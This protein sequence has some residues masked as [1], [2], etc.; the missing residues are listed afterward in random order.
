MTVGVLWVVLGAVLFGA[1]TLMQAHALAAVPGRAGAPLLRAVRHPLFLVG[2]AA[3][4]G[5]ALAH[6][7][8]LQSVPMAVAQAAVS[9]SLAVTVL[10]AR[11][12]FGSRVGAS[13]IVAVAVL[14][15]AL[16]ALA[17]VSGESGT[18]DE[19]GP[20]TV[21]LACAT[22]LLGIGA[23]LLPALDPRR[24][25]VVAAVVSGLG[26]AACSIATRLLDT[27]SLLAPLTDP[28]L[29]VLA[30]AG[31]LGALTWTV[32]LR[33]GTATSVTAIVV[34]SEVVPPSLLGPWLGDDVGTGFA[35]VAPLALLAAS[36]AA[37]T[38]ARLEHRTPAV[39]GGRGRSLEAPATAI[40]DAEVAR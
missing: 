6:V 1:G 13:G 40:L 3:E 2:G 29:L 21:A 4:A 32:A 36:V 25:A 38:L 28:A 27:S 5:G 37:V 12:V 33:H 8:A 18:L 10:G 11:L 17:T 7:A 22:A 15:G 23:T 34:V 19:A 30:A 16:V 9:G 31:A 24:R 35:V 20:A 14:S 26:F 39:P